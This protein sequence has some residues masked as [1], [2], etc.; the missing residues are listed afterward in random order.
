MPEYLNAVG[1]VDCEHDDTPLGSC[2]EWSGDWAEL[3]CIECCKRRA[4][5][6]LMR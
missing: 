1:C 5:F 6:V 3:H 4:D 2:V